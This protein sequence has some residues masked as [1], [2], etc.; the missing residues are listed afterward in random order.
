[1]KNRI[2]GLALFVALAF[3]TVIGGCIPE[4]SVEWSDDGSVGLMRVQ[5]ALYLVNGQTGKLTEI[6]C[7]EVECWPDIS[8]DGKWIAYTKVMECNSLPEGLKLLPA[9]QV[10]MIEYYAAEMKQQILDTHGI[11]LS[12]LN[13]PDDCPLKK[14]SA[15]WVVRYLCEK[16]DKELADKLGKSNIEQGKAE[17]IGLSQ[18]ILVPP[19]DLTRKKVIATT[20]LPAM[21]VRFAPNNKYLAYLT[22]AGSEDMQY[23]LCIASLDGSITALRV[24]YPVA[25]GYS[26]RDDSRAV[27]YFSTDEKNLQAEGPLIGS[28]KEKTI[29]DVNDKLLA[30][31]AKEGEQGTLETHQSTGKDKEAAGVIFYPWAS[32]KYGMDGRLLFCA[33]SLS[34]P[35][36][37]MD[38]ARMSIFCYDPVTNTVADIIPQ[39]ISPYL[40][41]GA[42]LNAFALSPDKKKLL[43]PM[44]KNRFAIYSLGDS[45]AKMPVEQSEGFGDK[46]EFKLA[47]AWKGTGEISC[48]VADNSHLFAN[49]KDVEGRQIVVI[50]PN[51]GLIRVLSRNWPAKVME[52]F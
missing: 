46:D 13:L 2:A 9:G 3:F 6:D 48:L 25:V 28:V 35:T 42:S 38:E 50:D 7:N 30:E 49:T 14:N 44:A 39:G 4:D 22:E 11:T 51:G 37:Q 41:G 1:M 23:S 52:K 24:D 33:Q 29:V 15:G 31:V 20:I 36:S 21:R 18:I 43:L 8:K 12:L 19:S 10:K 27:A 16:A 17:K 32:V 5:G 47:P 45:D 26:W 40:D 34:L